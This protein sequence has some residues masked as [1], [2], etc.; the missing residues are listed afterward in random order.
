VIT[1]GTVSFTAPDVPHPARKNMVIVAISHVTTLFIVSPFALFFMILFYY[2]F[3]IK[4]AFMILLKSLQ[5]F[6]TS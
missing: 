2:Y 5:L 3:S 1:G 6:F 4:A